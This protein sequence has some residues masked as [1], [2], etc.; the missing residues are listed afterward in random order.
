MGARRRR[1]PP[2][3]PRPFALDRQIRMQRPRLDLGSSHLAPLDPDPSIL[4]QT[5]R[6]ALCVLLKR[7]PTLPKST[8]S[9][10]LF[11]NIYAE[12]LFLA[13]YPLSFFKIGPAVHVRSFY[14]LDPEALV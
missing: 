14:E 12:V 7:P 8:S 10:I 2:P 1:V 11:K 9:P 5:Y 3:P 6:F 13:F 4:N